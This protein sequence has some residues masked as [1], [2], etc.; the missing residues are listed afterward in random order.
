[1]A[2]KA[3]KKTRKPA[4]MGRPAFEPTKAM[5]A[6]VRKAAAKGLPE[7][8]IAVSICGVHPHTFP[9]FKR[10]FPEL[11]E[12]L[13]LGRKDIADKVLKK[14]EKMFEEG[15]M[16]A[17]DKFIKYSRLDKHHEDEAGG[18]DERG[19]EAG[20][21]SSALNGILRRA[22]T[23]MERSRGSNGKGTPS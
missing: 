19:A 9:K 5:L 21:S 23:N 18:S 2:R 20:D 16:A 6:R 8:M 10:D 1:M 4:K 12:S 14:L 22:R 3:S 15:N 7:H 11:T 17:L 13:E